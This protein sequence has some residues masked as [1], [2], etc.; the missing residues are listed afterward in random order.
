MRRWQLLGAAAGCLVA[1]LI[2]VD[3]SSRPERGERFHWQ[4]GV[5]PPG[6]WK[7]GQFD[8][9]AADPAA[10]P[11]VRN[12]DR[13]TLDVTGTGEDLERVTDCLAEHGAEVTARRL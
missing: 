9:C 10:G 8:E 6:L 12:A 7:D 2:V 4:V 11:L 1:A 13:G 3:Q 5:D